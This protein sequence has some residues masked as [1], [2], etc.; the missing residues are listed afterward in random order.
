[1]RYA[2]P[3]L[4]KGFT[5]KSLWG[6]RLA[7]IAMF[8]NAVPIEAQYSVQPNIF[9]PGTFFVDGIPVGCGGVTF[10][11]DPNLN[12]VG[13]AAPGIIR[14]NPNVLGALPTTL[15]LFWVSHECGHH[16][17]GFSENAADCWAIR[18]GRDQG[19]FPPKAFDEMIAMFRNNPGDFS[20]APGPVRVQNM[21][22]CYRA[23]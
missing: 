9:P 10:V 4:V 20:H 15:K 19:W 8:V 2:A 21:I 22:N 23:P 18:L 6:R 13:Q 17:V 7:T 5:M 3:S 12:D 16:V 14:L 1:M 11:L